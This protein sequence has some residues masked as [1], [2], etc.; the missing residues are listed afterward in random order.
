[1]KQRQSL[2]SLCLL[3]ALL[4]LSGCGAPPA[5]TPAPSP[6]L[7]STAVPTFTPL[8]PAT[9]TAMPTA[10]PNLA[11]DPLTGLTVADPEALR[12]R[13]ILVRYG[14]DRIA[15]PPSGL[16]QADIV[17]EELAEGGFVTRLTGVYL[18]SLPEVVGPIRSARPAVID[19][20][21]QLDAALVYA[22]ASIGTGKLLAQQPYPQYDHV[23]KDGDLFFRSSDRPSPHNLYSRLPAVRARLAAQH[24][25]KAVDLQGLT[26]APTA[27][28][29][30]PATRLHIPYPGE[31]PVTY[32]YNAASGS[33]LRSVQGA[34]HIDALNGQQL[35]PQNVVVL[36]AEHKN[37]DIVEDSLG[38]VAILINW[39]GQGRVQVFR[40]GALIEGTWRREKPGQLTR[41]LDSEGKAIPLKPGQTWIEI[42]PL[43]YSVSVQ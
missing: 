19:M 23:G 32:V 20:M 12:H 35:A 28:A 17:Y 5:P 25:D 15:R 36:Y 6:Q 10:T 43:H 14:N 18:A 42:V 24:A 1:M 22:G 37:S 4:S 29:G 27:P 3:A 40:D 33:Y 30:K 34:P 8:P 21:Q 9:P 2:L 16:S 39:I 7:I 31:A 38:N 26:F 41:F 13:P 11:L